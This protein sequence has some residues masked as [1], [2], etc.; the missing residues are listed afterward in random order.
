M[1]K[2][3]VSILGAML[4]ASNVFGAETTNESVYATAKTYANM[5]ISCSVTNEGPLGHG[6]AVQKA[7][8]VHPTHFFWSDLHMRLEEPFWIYYNSSEYPADVQSGGESSYHKGDQFIAFLHFTH[9]NNQFRIIR[10][11]SS[12][13][14]PGIEKAIKK[15]TEPTDAA[16]ASHGQ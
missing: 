13:K 10:T 16:A 3:T 11:D 12:D 14:A 15:T 2:W 8:Q 1:M 7:Y 5:I 4:C 6:A 9:T